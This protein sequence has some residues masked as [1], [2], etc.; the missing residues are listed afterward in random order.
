MALPAAA[1]SRLTQY[2][3]RTL[4]DELLATLRHA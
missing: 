4:V 1:R 2:R 3:D